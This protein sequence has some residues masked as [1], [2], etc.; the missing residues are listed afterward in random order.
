MKTNLKIKTYNFINWFFYTGSDQDQEREIFNLGKN[1]VD[2]LLLGN[3]T[4]TAKNILEQC[5][6]LVIPL[7][8]IEGFENVDTF[9]EIEDAIADGRISE[10]F[11]IELVNA[12]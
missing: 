8:I 12:C 7:N 1:I 5:E 6:T 3:V 10:D 2:Q 11:E 4:I 9:D